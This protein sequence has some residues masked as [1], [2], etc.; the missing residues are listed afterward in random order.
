MNAEKFI[1]LIV[2]T[3]LTVLSAVGAVNVI[4]DPYRWFRL[5]E[6]DGFNRVKPLVRRYI[7]TTKFRNI[8][9]YDPEVLIL[10]TSTAELGIDPGSG[11]FQS[12]RVFNLGL[13]TASVNDSLNLYEMLSERISPSMVILVVDYTN[14]GASASARRR[15]QVDLP[16]LELAAREGWHGFLNRTD[17]KRIFSTRT[18]KDSWYTVAGQSRERIFVDRIHHGGVKIDGPV[19]ENVM[20]SGQGQNFAEY[21]KLILTDGYGVGRGKPFVFRVE[22]RI[23]SYH[24]LALLVQ[25]VRKSGADIVVAT[26]PMHA[27]QWEIVRQLGLWC[28]FENWKIGMANLLDMFRPCQGCGEVTFWDFSYAHSY[29]TEPVP[30]LGDKSTKM[31]FY[32]D[33]LHFKHVLGD[34]VLE[35]VLGGESDLGLKFE[36]AHMQAHNNFVRERQENYLSS[37]SRGPEDI[38]RLLRDHG[39]TPEEAFNC[40]N[41]M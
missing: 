34:A 27:R 37:G 30:A 15:I 8:S 5:V 17:L 32:W 9:T 13:P 14:F 33:A 21:E 23:D 18:L 24:H 20:R 1:L 7:T 19:E 4:V 22:G 11:Y 35:A 3:T 16:Y 29:A 12:R 2:L 28:D 26:A 38:A 40:R 41:L 10:G 39:V 25:K 6:E 31:Q 36:S